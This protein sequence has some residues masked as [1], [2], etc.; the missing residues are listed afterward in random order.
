MGGTDENECSLWCRCDA[1]ARRG[2]HGVRKLGQRAFS[3]FLD[4]KRGGVEEAHRS[5][6]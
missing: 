3:D 4:G 6:A 2:E 5:D 1:K